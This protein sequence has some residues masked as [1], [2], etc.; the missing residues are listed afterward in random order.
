MYKG[1]EKS[2]QK[3]VGVI[4]ITSTVCNEE[5]QEYEYPSVSGL[6]QSFG[7]S[8]LEERGKWQDRVILEKW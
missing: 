7:W 5:K 4:K 1:A 8:S 2:G 3:G 6:V